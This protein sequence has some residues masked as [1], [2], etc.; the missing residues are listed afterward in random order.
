[1]MA[2][3]IQT[4]PLNNEYLESYTSINNFYLKASE[5]VNND[6]TMVQEKKKT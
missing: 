6:Q 2:F 3:V 4:N 1:M 5:A